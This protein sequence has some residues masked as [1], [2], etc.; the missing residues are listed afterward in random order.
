MSQY[1]KIEKVKLFRSL[2]KGREDVFAIYWEKGRKHGYMPAYQYD[3]YMYRL[4]LYK[5]GTFKDYKD[6]NRRVHSNFIF[7]DLDE[8]ID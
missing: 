5:G 6:K 4:H 1:S 2:F 7:G 3:P 8:A